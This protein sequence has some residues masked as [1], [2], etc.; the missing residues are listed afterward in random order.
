MKNVVFTLLLYCSLAA[1]SFLFA[2]STN[3]FQD[4]CLEL[5]KS[6]MTTNYL[7][8]HTWPLN[9][10]SILSGS[11]SDTISPDDFSQLFFD[12]K[13]TE[14]GAPLLPSQETYH[15]QV[16]SHNELYRIPL[17]IIHQDFDFL[18]KNGADSLFY[19]E[20]GRYKKAADYTGSL[21][22]Q[23]KTFA[24]TNLKAVSFYTTGQPINFILPTNLVFAN[25]TDEITSISVDFANGEG[26]KTISTDAEIPVYYS[27]GGT[28]Q[29]AFQVITTSDT[30]YGHSILMLAEVH[31]NPTSGIL[32]A[33]GDGAL[34]Y[35]DDIISFS[36]NGLTICGVSEENSEANAYIRYADS[37]NPVLTR[38]LIFVEGIDFVEADQLT[39]PDDGRTIRHGNFGW[40]V[41]TTGINP[42]TGEPSIPFQNLPILVDNASADG[43]DVILLDFA[44]GTGFIQQNADLLI[45]LIRWV[46]NN[47][48]TCEQNVVAG[49]SMGGIITRYALT[50]M[51]KE[52]EDHDTR[53]YIS[54]DAAHQGANVPAGLQ[55]FWLRLHDKLGFIDDN[56]EPL[57]NIQR[58]AAKQLLKYHIDEEYC[59]REALLS[60]LNELGYPERCRNV[61]IVSGSNQGETGIQAPLPGE[62]YV[63]F[64]QYSIFPYIEL[65]IDMWA[66]KR[67]DHA[68]E[69][70]VSHTEFDLWPFHPLN[71][72][73]DLIID[74]NPDHYI[75]PSQFGALDS[76]PGGSRSTV[77]D[78]LLPQ[79][80]KIQRFFFFWYATFL[81]E[82]RLS[83]DPLFYSFH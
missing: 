7:A 8:D 56:K 58:P 45:Q 39:I 9:F 28:K 40:D 73:V 31:N 72:L 76:A 30:L 17:G 67:K 33:S 35:P 44:N 18:K 27:S 78:D 1:S 23:S 26:F 59:M 25:A 46:N 43:Y 65:D 79:L 52:E 71:Y 51:E 64:N 4:R 38:P 50:T 55:S 22:Q 36:T 48:T 57:E 68:G 12:L 81:W 3:V 5:D 37:D 66:V 10:M 21:Y 13:K 63:D 29:L 74:G 82:P 69:Q 14:I 15:D 62:K 16:K 61:A 41:L 32:S 42:K 70:K 11:I 20:N 83:S 54:M 60:E 80:E 75:T 77:E 47:K 6:N 19:L 24:M 2:Q 49:A 34:C 53:L